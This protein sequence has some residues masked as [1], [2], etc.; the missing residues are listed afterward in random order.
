MSLQRLLRINST[1]TLPSTTDKKQR[2]QQQEITTAS[3]P[4][5]LH[6]PDEIMKDKF[7]VTDNSVTFFAKI[8]FHRIPGWGFVFE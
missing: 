1:T 6:A 7:A 4:K 5:T 8:Q 2:E 3:L